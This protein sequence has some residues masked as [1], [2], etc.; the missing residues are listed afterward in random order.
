VI[1]DLEAR[2]ERAR[3]RGVSEQYTIIAAQAEWW[4]EYRLREGLCFWCG[5]KEPPCCRSRGL[6]IPLAALTHLQHQ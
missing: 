2:V 5:G 1:D 3:A 4:S 6:P